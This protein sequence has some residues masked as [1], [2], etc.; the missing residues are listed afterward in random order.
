MFA[1][2][3]VPVEFLI[4]ILFNAFEN[5]VLLVSTLMLL[6]V[7]SG[8]EPL[9]TVHAFEWFLTC[10][11]SDVNLKVLEGRELFSAYF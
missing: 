1:Q 4:T 6:H 11:P 5:L 9:L 10:V 3:E 2:L 8:G 7:A